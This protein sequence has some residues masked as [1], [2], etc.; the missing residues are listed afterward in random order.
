MGRIRNCYPKPVTN[1]KLMNAL[2]AVVFA[3]FGSIMEML[4]K[5]F[6]SWFPPTGGD[7][8]SARAIW[9]ALMGALQVSLGVGFLVRAYVVPVV[10]RM[11][12]TVPVE[13]GALAL[14]GT[15]GVT[16]R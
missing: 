13:P 5:A 2:N 14:P 3:A 6:P 7:Q 10:H 15:R 16:F 4:P 11:L 8:A 12:S 1:H 9:L